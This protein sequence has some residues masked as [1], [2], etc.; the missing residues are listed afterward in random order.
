MNQVI[1]FEDIEAGSFAPKRSP[2]ISERLLRVVSW[3][4]NRGCHF[5][6]ILEFLASANADLILLQECDRNALRSNGRNV[7]RDIAQHLEMNYV[8]GIEFLELSQ[9][10]GNA[11]AHHG[12]ATL[13][14]FP[15]LNPRVLRFTHQSNFWRPRWFLPSIPRLQRR[16][17]GRMALACETTLNQTKMAIYNLHIE[18]RSSERLRYRQMGEVLEDARR[19]RS[20]VP[21]VMAGDFNFDVTQRIAS[22][23]IQVA[24]FRNAFADGPPEVST[25]HRLLRHS[26]AID[27]ILVAGQ[28]VSADPRIHASARGSD[29][30]PLSLSL[31]SA[32]PS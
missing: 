26:R 14:R 19:Y 1:A 32:E 16:L 4:I 23:A 12:Q 7:A 6:E 5:D 29:H 13:C 31:S 10:T 9:G 15:L 27:S 30:Y 21:I 28:L 2:R 24:G 18:S 20:H 25:Q 8:F 22:A 17:G 3:N 11:P